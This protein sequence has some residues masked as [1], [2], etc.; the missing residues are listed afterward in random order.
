[1][2]AL[3]VLSEA[4]TVLPEAVTVLFRGHTEAF[5]GSKDVS[6]FWVLGVQGLKFGV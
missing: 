6:W 3:T 2:L 5:H 4:V 1:M